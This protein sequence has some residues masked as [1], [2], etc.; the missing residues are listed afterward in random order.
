M[1]TLLSTEMTHPLNYSNS[2]SIVTSVPTSGTGGADAS[3]DASSRPLSALRLGVEFGRS[4]QKADS[5]VDGSTISDLDPSCRRPPTG[6]LMNNVDSAVRLF[7]H[8]C[9]VTRSYD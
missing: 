4:G 5:D 3:S 7:T 1:R 2:G 9:K 6:K 8:S